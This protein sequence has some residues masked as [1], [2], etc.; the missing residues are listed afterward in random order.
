[1][2]TVEM[3]KVMVQRATNGGGGLALMLLQDKNVRVTDERVADHFMVSCMLTIDRLEER[4]V[5]TTQ[6]RKPG[7]S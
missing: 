5:T 1:M 6:Y 7:V 4:G 2:F 3:E